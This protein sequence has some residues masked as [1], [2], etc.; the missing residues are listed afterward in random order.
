ME[1]V[2]SIEEAAAFTGLSKAYIYKLIFLKKIPHYKPL[3]GRIF[4]K[5]SEL[6]SFI[7]RGRRAADYELS[8]R[9]EK[10]LNKSEGAV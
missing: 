5:Q 10:I 1:K 4:F 3:G 7:F 6:E 8:D 2:F 9:A